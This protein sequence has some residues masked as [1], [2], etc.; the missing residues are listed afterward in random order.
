MVLVCRKS[1]TLFVAW[2]RYFLWRMLDFVVID[3]LSQDCLIDID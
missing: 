1:L 3:A 2:V